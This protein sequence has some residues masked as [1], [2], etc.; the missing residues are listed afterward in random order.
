MD[1]RENIKEDLKRFNREE[2]EKKMLESLKKASE[3]NKANK[4][5]FPKFLK[6]GRE[7]GR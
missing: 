2:Y 1:K 5:K 6:K 7:E 4:S 3:A